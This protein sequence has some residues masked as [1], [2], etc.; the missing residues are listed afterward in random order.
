MKTLIG[1][2]WRDYFLDDV[3]RKVMWDYLQIKHKFEMN[4]LTGIGV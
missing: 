1:E 2:F 4:S 3:N